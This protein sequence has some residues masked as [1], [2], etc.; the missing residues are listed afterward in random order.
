MQKLNAKYAHFIHKRCQNFPKS[1]NENEKNGIIN[2]I[3]SELG[4]SISQSKGNN[5]AKK[6]KH[7][8]G[9]KI[10]VLFSKE[11]RVQ[12]RPRAHVVGG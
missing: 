6:W 8:H 7:S 1:W 5:R 9:T 2:Q 3:K 10:K 11:K 12:Q 4:F